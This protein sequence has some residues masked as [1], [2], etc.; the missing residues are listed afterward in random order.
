MFYK[1]KLLVF[2]RIEIKVYRFTIFARM[3]EEFSSKMY[4]EFIVFKEI[5]IKF[6]DH[7]PGAEFLL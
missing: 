6:K 7:K 4:A 1:Q 5:D 3:Q 2:L